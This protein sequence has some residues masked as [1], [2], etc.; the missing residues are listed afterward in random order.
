MMAAV[1]PSEPPLPGPYTG[2]T[3]MEPGGTA[4]AAR[5]TDTLTTALPLNVAVVASYTDHT[6]PPTGTAGVVVKTKAKR[7]VLA[8]LG[9]MP[10]AAASGS[11]TASSATASDATSSH[12]PPAAA[13][14]R[15][16]TGVADCRA[17]TGENTNCDA[18]TA[19]SPDA[20][21][22]ASVVTTSCRVRM[23]TNVP[24][25]AASDGSAR[26]NSDG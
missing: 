3:P 1:L 18:S 7:A 10:A 21:P 14:Y 16:Y 13:L 19:A 12:S 23:Y 26:C 4:T 25:S 24:P 8:P 20:P 5:A 6:S 9:T 17:Y 22:P 15:R 11:V 2:G